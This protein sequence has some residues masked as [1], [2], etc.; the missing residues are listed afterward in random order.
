MTS[1]ISVAMAVCR[2]ERFIGAQLASL[3]GQSVP[4]D[5]IV[6]CDDSPDDATEQAITAV[7]DDHP[8]IIRYYR[9]ATQLGVSKNFERAIGLTTGNVIFLCDQDDVW[10]PDKIR[11]LQELLVAA[12]SPSGAFCNSSMVDAELCELGC[13]IWSL[14]D[15]SIV[16][17]QCFLRAN[18]LQRLQRFARLVPASGHNMAF[19]ARL[20]ELLLPFPELPE[21]HDTWIGLV[22]EAVT[23]GWL[24]AEQPLT[25]FRR[26]DHNVSLTGKSGRLQQ[27]LDSIRNNT[28]SWHV[29]FYDELLQRLDKRDFSQH[30]A[31]IALLR[32]RRAH[33][34]ARVAMNCRNIFARLPLILHEI[35]NRRYFRFGRGWQNV[36]QDLLLRP[37]FPPTDR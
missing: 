10:L 15:F 12:P 9:N 11:T 4:P 5:E 6:I 25:L 34:A 21:C 18:R 30:D 2:G 23:P 16:A 32:D 35:V 7:A 19:D 17:R 14:R 22:I 31:I 27:A 1:K 24:I 36:I 33:S 20:K 3:L 8:G 29:K 13:D 37:P 28:F 26:H